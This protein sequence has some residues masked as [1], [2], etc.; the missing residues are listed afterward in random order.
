MAP[1]P[2]WLLI[3]QMRLHVPYGVRTGLRTQNGKAGKG[4]RDPQQVTDGAEDSGRWQ[5]VVKVVA[6]SVND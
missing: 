4:N 1:G 5:I 3:G 6:S 2:A